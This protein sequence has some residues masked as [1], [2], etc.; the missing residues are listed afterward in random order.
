MSRGV[1]LDFKI[2]EFSDANLLNEYFQKYNTG[3]NNTTLGGYFGWRKLLNTE[4]VIVDE[5][6]IIKNAFKNNEVRFF[7][8]VGKNVDNAIK[9]LIDYSSKNNIN[10]KFFPIS[11]D[12]TKLFDKYFTYEIK[13]ID[14]VGDYIYDAESLKTMAGRKLHGQ[15]NHLNYFMK[16]YGDC[17]IIDISD[18]NISEIKA[19]IQENI[20]ADKEKKLFMYKAEID[21]NNEVLDNIDMYKFS[22]FIVKYESKII[23]LILGEEIKDTA[24][25]HIMKLNKSYRGI[26]QYLIVNFLS[27]CSDKV[28]YAN[29]EDDADDEDLKYTKKCYHPL[30]MQDINLLTVKEVKQGV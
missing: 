14:N 1:T 24:F 27:R 8:P 5:T 20:N 2:I 11:M 26:A 17:E 12:E 13:H 21:Y 30:H 9:W 23:G 22:G 19:F 15:K 6:L 4:Y 25:L 3:Y 18:A 7:I 10:L 28:K 29:M 16:T